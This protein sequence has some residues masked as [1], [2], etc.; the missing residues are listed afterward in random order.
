MGWS[1]LDGVRMAQPGETPDSCLW[2]LSAQLLF[3]LVEVMGTLAWL[4]STETRTKVVGL[5]GVGEGLEGGGRV[6]PFFCTQRP[7]G[8][9]GDGVGAQS[10][11]GPWET[12]L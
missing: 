1:L 11:P 4:W 12:A 10:S 9:A 6:Q 2:V 7:Q 8:G 3:L 5:R